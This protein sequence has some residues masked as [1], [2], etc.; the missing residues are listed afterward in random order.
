MPVV[1][2]YAISERFSTAGKI[3]LNYQ[4][5]P[6]TNIKRTT[7]LRAVLKPVMVTAL[8]PS[9]AIAPDTGSS[10]TTTGR[11]SRRYKAPL[12][13]NDTFGAGVLIR[14]PIDMDATLAFFDDRFK[15]NKPFI[16]ASEICD[17]PFVPKPQAG[18]IVPSGTTSIPTIE[19]A[20][21]TFWNSPVSPAPPAVPTTIPRISLTGDNSIE[22]PYAITYPRV[23]SKSNTYQIHVRAQS[24]RVSPASAAAGEFR[25]ARDGIKGEF[26][27]SFII[28][29]YLDPSV[30]TYDPAGTA[31][32]GPYKIRVISSKQLAL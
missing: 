7:G 12:Y 4:I 26:R 8:N 17:I 23:T 3:N 30:Q 20:L 27:G 14:H 9:E 32:L 21:A 25:P 6:F 28:E 29:R 24:L 16:S 11:F 1:E 10:T 18:A 2:P 5:A 22:R 15:N 13:S 19:A 31:G